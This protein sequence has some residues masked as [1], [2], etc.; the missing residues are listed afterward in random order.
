M[1]ASPSQNLHSF[2][3]IVVV[4]SVIVVLS[5]QSVAHTVFHP[6][7]V[8]KVSIADYPVIDSKALGRDKNTARL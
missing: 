6:T 8:G 2:I 7:Q 5:P 3:L 1:A 4:C